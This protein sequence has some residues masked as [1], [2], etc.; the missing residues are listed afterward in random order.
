[1][2]ARLQA[3][4]SRNCASVLR[5]ATSLFLPQSI[6][7]GC[8]SNLSFYPMALS[9]VGEA[10]SEYSAEIKN[11]WRNTSTPVCFCV[12]HTLIS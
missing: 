1:V 11:E 2:A 12:M 9:A 10:A 8:A 5:G 6:Q 4:E 7:T 3:R